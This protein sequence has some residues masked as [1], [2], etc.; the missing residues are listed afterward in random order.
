[1]KRLDN[2]DENIDKFFR[3]PVVNAECIVA[4]EKLPEVGLN[5]NYAIDNYAQAYCVVVF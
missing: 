3:T 5:C 2:Q 1:M 4:V